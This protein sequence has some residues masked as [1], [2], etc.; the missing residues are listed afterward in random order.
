MLNVQRRP[1]DVNEIP[2]EDEVDTAIEQL[3]GTTRP[4]LLATRETT[5][6]SFRDNAD[7]S[8]ALKAMFR[9]ASGWGKL[10]SVEKEAMDMIAL[11]FS[12]VLS[13]RSLETQHWEDVVGYAQLALEQCRTGDL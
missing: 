4:P 8:Q 7:V 3:A 11:K 6:G 13:G 2:N 9:S 12:R 5:H 10:T 1:F